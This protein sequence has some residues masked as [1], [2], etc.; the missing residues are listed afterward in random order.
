MSAPQE[1]RDSASLGKKALRGGTFLAVATVIERLAR[2]GRNMLLARIIVP[3]QFGL[4]ALTMSVLAVLG[5]ITEVGVSHAV[6]QNKRGDTPEFLNVAWWFG[7]VRGVVVGI[8]AILLAGPVARL[9]D[10]PELGKLL[11]VAPVVILFTGLTSPKVFALQRK[12]QFK[13]TL[14]TNQGAALLG[15]MLTIVLGFLLQ[16][17]WA[18]MWGAV[19]EFFCRFVLSFILCPIRIRF[20]LDRVSVRDLLKFT[21][22]MA[23]LSILTMLVIQADTAVLGMVVSA[24]QLGLYAFAIA[25][26]GFPLGVFTSVIEPLIVPV[27]SQAQD[28][29]E[30]L[31]RRV[32][33]LSRLVWLFG[34]PLMAT[35]SIVAEPLLR[36]LYGP[37]FG[38]AAHAFALY[39]A[40]VMV[41]MNSIV[42]FFVYVA[43]GK[44]E[45]QRRFTLV[46][47]L[48][49]VLLLYP[50]SV[51]LGIEGAALA[52]LIAMVGSMA[53][54]LFNL[55]R[56]I[57]LGVVSFLAT[58]RA[59]AGAAACVSVP[60][61]LIVTLTHL[62][63]WAKVLTCAAFGG[64]CWA[65]LLL[66]ERR[67]L[68]SLRQ[69]SLR[70]PS[71]GRVGTPHS[72][73]R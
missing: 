47:A 13:A 10:E 55:R 7:V 19:F 15:T 48:L 53:V 8:L 44:P 69:G 14:W 40:F 26:A 52:L 22:G 72:D 57:G 37:P 71:E 28:D 61:L 6:V 67:V 43:I 4:M 35:L 62:P 49:V 20:R 29:F 31:R 18:L 27:L 9:Y 56:V 36:L 70:S 45:L 59:G 41:Y 46:R 64:A 11:L 38:E 65:L 66:R 60:A 23:G 21:R 54:Q 63:D 33:A 5:A 39:C 16:N 34:L 42:S 51:L 3:D 1:H 17:V 68:A 32:L 2:L 12:F 73:L 30:A 24:H 50:L 25:L 58:I